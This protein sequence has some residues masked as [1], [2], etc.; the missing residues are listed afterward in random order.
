[1][2]RYLSLLPIHLTCSSRILISFICLAFPQLQK[3]TFLPLRS[4]RPPSIANC[5]LVVLAGIRLMVYFLHRLLLRI[6][7]IYTLCELF[8]LDHFQRGFERLL[9]AVWPGRSLLRC[10]RSEP[11][12]SL[13]KVDAC[14]IMRDP[15]GTSRGFAFMTFE[16]ANAV[17]LVVS[18]EHELDGKMV[19]EYPL[20]LTRTT[21]CLL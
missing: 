4:W 1:M 18:R 21:N 19:R 7:L 16:D 10:L 6:L 8:A 13:G 3:N 14:T 12:Y 17:N 2:L 9:F 15:S 11:A 20:T 5:L